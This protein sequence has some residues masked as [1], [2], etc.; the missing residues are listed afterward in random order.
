MTKTEPERDLVR[1]ILPLFP[2][3]LVVSYVVG[4]LAGGV[5]G[6]WSA[7]IGVFVVGANFA[8]AALAIA[9]AAGIS[10]VM[11]YAVALGGFLFRLIV[12]TVALVALNTL[13]WFSPLAFALTV[14]PATA[15]LLVLEMRLTSGRTQADLWYFR[16]RT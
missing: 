3:A 11:I 6:G 2:V 8:A 7:A 16:E 5:G 9:W 13:A 12:I 10:A 15:A 14:V 4:W 1:R